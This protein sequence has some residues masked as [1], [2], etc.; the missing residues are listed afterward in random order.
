MFDGF[1]F[2][3]HSTWEFLAH[4]EKYPKQNGP[5]RKRTTVAVAGRNGALHFQNG[6]FENYIQPYEIYFH[7]E[8]PTPEMAHKIKSWLLSDGSYQRLEDVYDPGYFRMATFAGP[9]N[10]DNVLNMY[11]R[12]TI[13]FDCAP[14]SFLVSG[15]LPLTFEASGK[16]LNPTNQIALPKIVAYGTGAGE[17][18]VNGTA[19]RIDAITD[20]II[21]DCEVENAYSEVEGSAAVNQNGNIYAPKF[22]T[23]APGT[24]TVSF[25]GDITKLEI[26]PRW[27]TL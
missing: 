17:V 20:P 21:L 14:Q 6:A 12:C 4:V 23:L 5:K 8:I 15:E 7:G 22:P 25:S 10:I 13:N 3:G 9:L 16:I 18:S 2:G 24:N 11:G 1:T 19:V 26:T 27:W